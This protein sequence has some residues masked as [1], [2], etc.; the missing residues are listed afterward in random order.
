M[1]THVN[2]CNDKISSLYGLCTDGSEAVVGKTAGTV[3]W[4]KSVTTIL[5]NYSFL[6]NHS[7]KT[8]L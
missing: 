2:K 5:V 4:I 3:T 8:L 1:N 6:P 7:S